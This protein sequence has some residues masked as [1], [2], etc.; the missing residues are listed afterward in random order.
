MEGKI[1]ITILLAWFLVFALVLT[2]VYL[3]LNYRTKFLKS[4]KDKQLF[5]IQ[6]A[7]EAEEQQ[8][9]RLANN[10]HDDIMPLLTV[11]GQNIN[12]HIRDFSNNTLNPEEFKKDLEILEESNKGMKAIALD[13]VPTTFL[14]FGLLKALAQHAGQLNVDEKVVEYTDASNFEHGLPFSKT[15][16]INIYRIYKEILN[17]L[18]KHAAYT[19]LTI[20]LRRTNAEFIIQFYHDGFSITNE[21]IES[22]SRVSSGLGLKSLKARLLILK[23]QINYFKKNGLPI[24][25][26]IIPL[27]ND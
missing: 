3:S 16:Q 24:I 22:I 10:L 19:C 9:E 1:E 7:I 26:L 18:T 2:I 8:K 5:A 15:E 17:N 23:A 25:E 11:L 20:E 27:K 21:Q 6:S 14:N 12:R 4:E 13:L